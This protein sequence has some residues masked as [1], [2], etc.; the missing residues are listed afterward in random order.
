MNLGQYI[1][2]QL[3]EAEDKQTIALFPGAFKPPHKGHFDVVEKLLK[4]ADQVVVLI[5]PKVRDG[6]SSDESVAVWNL[7]KNKLNGPV[8]IRVAAESPVSE[9]YDVVKN[10]PDTDFLVA[11]GKGEMERYRSMEKYPNVKVFDAGA[12]EGASATNLRMALVSKN[13]EEIKK[14]LPQGI[15]L[16]EFMSAL[17]KETEQPKE[18]PVQAQPQQKQPEQ[19]IQESPPVD[20]MNDDYY[21]YVQQNRGKIE[22]VAAAFNFPIEDM[23]FAFEGG[24]EIVLTDD[25]WKE[26]QNSKSYNMKSL[27][28]AIAHALKIGINPKPYI[29]QIKQK[30]DLPL[31][32]VLRYS[33]NKYY[34]VGGEVI[35]SIFRALGSIPTILLG[36]INMQTKTLPEPIHENIEGK[37]TES[38]T[39]T[40]GEF[41]KYSIQN[42]G[43]QQPPKGLTLS[44]NND[45]AKQR[46]SFG[47]FDPNNDKIWLYVR[48]RNMADILRTLA[49]EL[50]HRK[51]AEDG[52][53]DMTSGETGSEIENEANAMAGILLRDFGKQNPMIYEAQENDQQYK[54]FCDMDGVLVDFDGGY[55]KLTNKDIK[56]TFS[57]DEEF[58]DPISK[59]GIK[60]WTGL[61]WLPDGKQLWDYI[62]Q[63]NP[64]LLSAPSREESSKIG[65]RIWV[66]R[67]LPGVPLLL[68]AAK[69]KQEYASPDAILID[70]R[71]DN[72]DRW[73][74]AGGVGIYHTSASDTIKQLQKLGL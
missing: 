44:Y 27:D 33:Q 25:I 23:L 39:G 60:F 61:K 15:S 11:F 64:K 26:L 66:K 18:Q 10:N 35:L 47:T 69:Y 68:K 16:E 1:A 32:M 14:Y 34:L 5:S 8:E 13:E 17:S 38:Q 72:V 57:N 28:D 48:N 74:A 45:E 29:E 37:L 30:K 58:W 54:I 41:I 50:V 19:P 31:P 70:D 4:A 65:K 20:D 43:I 2:Q 40:I 56:G 21:N 6:V 55:K 51:Q 12:I 59:A 52:R 9:T 7:Y 3:L 62:K 24:Q 36:T 63:Y 67:N 49:H 42:L 71:K 53:I 46:C 73:N 22:K